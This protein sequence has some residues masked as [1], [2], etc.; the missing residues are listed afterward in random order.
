M[1]TQVHGSWANEESS[2]EEYVNDAEEEVQSA[3]DQS[4]KD[5]AISQVPDRATA[6]NSVPLPTSPPYIVR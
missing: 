2:D 3:P 4:A 6:S 1:S 5:G